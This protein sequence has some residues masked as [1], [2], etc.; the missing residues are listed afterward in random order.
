MV[1][2]PSSQQDNC[3]IC[4][5]DYARTAGS[6]SDIEWSSIKDTPTTLSGYGIT[7]AATKSELNALA[8]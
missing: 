8:A 2:V 7:D 6:S 3:Y 1:A 4:S 5:A